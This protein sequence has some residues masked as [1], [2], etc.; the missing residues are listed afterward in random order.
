MV[1]VASP[2]GRIVSPCAVIQPPLERRQVSWLS[3]RHPAPCT[4]ENER[5]WR[6]AIASNAVEGSQRLRHV[7]AVGALPELAQ[8][9]KFFRRAVR[10][11]AGGNFLPHPPPEGRVVLSGSCAVDD[12]P[13]CI[14][15]TGEA[16]DTGGGV[17]DD[18]RPKSK[19]YWFVWVG[20]PPPVLSTVIHPPSLSS[21]IAGKI[22]RR[23]RPMVLAMC[24]NA[25][26]ALAGFCIVEFE[27]QCRCYDLRGGRKGSVC[28]QPPQEGVLLRRDAFAWVSSQRHTPNARGA[29]ASASAALIAQRPANWLMAAPGRRRGCVRHRVQSPVPTLRRGRRFA[30]SE[31]ARVRQVFSPSPH[32]GCLPALKGHKAHF[33]A[34]QALISFSW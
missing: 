12:T 5:R 3:C 4:F 10:R 7:H 24:S 31:L 2:D 19:L 18:T 29:S 25:W 34:S 26:I 28:H 33:T 20:D 27:Q 11:A 30:R 1:A 9:F 17:A 14:C 22:V 16:G 8:F 15:D 23:L 6:I 13:S 32:Q 21:A